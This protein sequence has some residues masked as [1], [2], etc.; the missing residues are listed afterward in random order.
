MAGNDP[1]GWTEPKKILVILAH[2]DDPEFFCGATIA[3]WTRL[4]HNVQYGLLTRGDKGGNGRWVDPG[5]LMLTRERE[6]RAAGAVM[7]VSEITFMDYPDGYL[8]PSLETRREVVRLIRRTRPNVVV[9]CDPQNLFP[10]ENRI[11]HP[12]HLAAGRI[13]MEAVYPAAGNALFFTEL[14]EDGLTAH[15]VEEVWIASTRDANLTV[16]VTDTWETKIKALHEHRSQIEDLD[17]FDKMMRQRHTPES[18]LENPRYVE[19]FRRIIF[20]K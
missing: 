1:E 11:N 12:D 7:G 19:S 8:L 9:T 14:M 16:D 20:G 18:S 2:P 4:G 10:R 13:V 3:R 5:E 15:P 6:Q 17:A